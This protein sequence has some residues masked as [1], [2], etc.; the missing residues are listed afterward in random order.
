MAFFLIV[1]TWLLKG[2]AKIVPLNK[3]KIDRHVIEITNEIQFEG[4]M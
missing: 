3:M 4:C 2:T 1:W